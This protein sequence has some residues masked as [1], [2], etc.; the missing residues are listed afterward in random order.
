MFSQLIKKTNKQT[1]QP[2]GCMNLAPIC[3][4]SMETAGVRG[5]NA[6]QLLATE[7]LRV[8]PVLFAQ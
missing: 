8:R 6:T 2:L 4:T 3:F 5:H 1:K 7:P